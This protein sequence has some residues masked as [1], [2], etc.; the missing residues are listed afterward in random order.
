MPM[1]SSRKM[2]VSTSSVLHAPVGC[3]RRLPFVVVSQH[4]QNVGAMFE[5]TGRMYAAWQ[6]AVERHAAS[7]SCSHEPKH[8][9]HAGSWTPTS[10]GHGPHW[11]LQPSPPRSNGWQTPFVGLRSSSAGSFCTAPADGGQMSSSPLPCC[12][13]YRLQPADRT[14]ITTRLRMYAHRARRAPLRPIRQVRVSPR[15]CIS[16]SRSRTSF[17]QGAPCAAS[18]HLI[19]SSRWR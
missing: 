10:S 3:S 12:P 14:A 7:S 8:D 2:Q 16:F 15:A 6:V 1:Q 11:L 18:R 9:G 5:P 4:C 17:L 19:R 13:Q